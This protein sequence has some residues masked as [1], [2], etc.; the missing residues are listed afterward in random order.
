VARIRGFFF[1][2][3][4]ERDFD[5]E[6]ESHLALA[7][8]EKIRRGLSPEEAR[9]AARL[10]L[11]GLT[12]LREAGR[13]VRGLP[14]LDSFWL[15]VKLGLR[16]LRKSWGLTLIGGLAM[17]IA[18]AIGVFV[19]VAF[20][21]A[22]G[23]TLPLDEGDRVVAL[24]TW[25]EKAQRREGV[26]WEDLDRWRSAL[27]SVE[28]IGAFRTVETNLILGD[29]SATPGFLSRS[30]S[31]PVEPVLVAEMSASG[32]GLAR[33][34]AL[35]GRTL[36]RE[37]EAEGAPPVVVIGY[38][39]WQSR[40]SANPAIVGRTL[41]LGDTIRTIVGVMPEG[42]AFPVNHRFWAPL[43]VDRSSPLP[44]PPD[45]AVFARLAPGVAREGA[46]AEL[47]AL[48][49][50]PAAAPGG[51][52]RELRA[53]VESYPFAFSGDM[54]HGQALWV[55]RLILVLVTLL[56][57]PP[58]ANIAILVYA[59]IIMRQEEFAARYALGA[60]RGR[61]VGQLFV[62]MLVLAAGA[63]G[64][65]LVLVSL[66]LRWARDNLVD[67]ASGGAPFWMDFSLSWRSVLFA[68]LL[69]TV[70]A[71]IAGLGPALKATGRRMQ[72]GLQA[73][74]NRTS[75]KL[76]ATW[77]GLV[78]A[79]VALSLAV[80]PIAVETGW[81]TVR[82]GILGP[83]FAAEDYLTARLAMTR[84]T[85]AGMAAAGTGP[86]SGAASFDSRFAAVQ[87]ELVEELQA[88]AGVLG[89][90]LA[91]LPGDEPWVRVEMEEAPLA[92]S[93]LAGAD[94]A[95]EVLPA[96]SLVRASRVDEAFFEVFEIPLLTGRAFDPGDFDSGRTPVIVNRTF[97]EEVLGKGNALG[98][99]LR[100]V[101]KGEAAEA[102]S[103]GS[104]VWYEV[105]GVVEDRP[106]NATN[107]TIY[108]PRTPGPTPQAGQ[109]SPTSQPSISLRIAADPAYLA[110]R[111]RQIAVDLDPNL[112]VDEVLT[113]DEVYREQAVGNNLGA[114]FLG[115]LTL[116]VLLLSAAGIYALMS[117]T[118]SRRRRE[119]GI[120]SALG[121]Q[122]VRL[123]AG[124]FQRVLRQLAAGATGGLLVA[125]LLGYLLPAE[126]VGGWSVPGIIPMATVFMMVVGLLAAVGPARRGLRVDPI[127][128]LRN[129]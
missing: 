19:F 47:T 89:V 71:V 74:G 14:W 3:D 56:L 121:A 100:Y 5:E 96:R 44:P 33:V 32:F 125:L 42:F 23:G 115:A 122:P 51:G 63:A 79:Q 127:D 13:E 90:T 43:R 119:I 87:R 103:S 94:S 102:A 80:L 15:D 77:S 26:S 78:V 45:G 17:T 124:I 73:L 36:T 62:E 61:I 98:R 85:P 91:T 110:E 21:L 41:R 76:G 49:L 18:V 12:Q 54:D 58:C 107:G 1:S 92:L 108:H 105:V 50:L 11:G 111:L 29:G 97:V 88:E 116:S 82:K 67:P 118:I 95:Q 86:G 117:F 60:S 123:L 9:R 68:A 6:L 28:G 106:A 66:T 27:R 46:Q 34:P 65:A 128:E 64:V 53:Q 2:R 22:Y 39:V 109:P 126:T 113:L 75:M 99:R 24:M 84:E 30:T 69:A 25:D 70:A 31:G 57:V 38:D 101:A 112:R 59:R 72:S 120:R 35:L 104:Q 10:E 114:A 8:E 7:E 52:D 4:L 81:G 129:G 55:V 83:G 48:G 37:D 93:S 16:M 20:D 40:F